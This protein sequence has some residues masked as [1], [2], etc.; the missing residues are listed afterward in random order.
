MAEARGKEKGKIEGKI[1]EKQTIALNLLNQGL[2]IDLIA[3]ANGL[4]ISQ[5]QVLQAQL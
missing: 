4:T 3:E 2:A 1:E 5:V